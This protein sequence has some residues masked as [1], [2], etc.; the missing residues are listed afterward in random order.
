MENFEN[1]NHALHTGMLWG[2]LMRAGL[3][4]LPEVDDYDNYTDVI[5]IDYDAQTYRIKVLP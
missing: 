1:P 5:A 2:I 3:D 4:A